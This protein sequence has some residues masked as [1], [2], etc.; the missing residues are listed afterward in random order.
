MFKKIRK[1]VKKLLV[2]YPPA[3]RLAR[4]AYST[5]KYENYSE[6]KRL[7]ERR[8]ESLRTVGEFVLEPGIEGICFKRD[9][10]VI[11]MADGTRYF[12]NLG[13]ANPMPLGPS[14]D[15]ETK[16]LRGI[17]KKGW[18]ALDVG[19]NFGWYAVHFSKF[20]GSSGR[21]HCF[22]PTPE[23][24]GLLEKNLKLNGCKNV[25]VNRIA[26]GKANGSITLIT[27]EDLGTA[28]SSEHAAYGKRTV[29]RV[30]KL[31]DYVKQDKARKIDMIKAD[32]EGGEFNV[33]L[34]AENI[35]R[36]CGPDLFLETGHLAEG[37]G[38]RPEDMFEFLSDKGY[39][40]SYL[41]ESGVLARLQ[42]FSELPTNNF[43][44]RARR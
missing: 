21:V 16:F 13:S 22:E 23:A 40:I 9:E 18:T 5:I 27:P 4:E 42:T 31:D 7:F 1:G 11:Q 34:G 29:V 3:Y 6:I 24:F 12:L 30:V 38:Y 37:F 39:E 28:F 36:N 8:L 14:E 17:M 10:T 20:V 32:V 41:K 15:N 33:L 25:A 26:V 43:Y 19:A 2:H 35:I 44:C